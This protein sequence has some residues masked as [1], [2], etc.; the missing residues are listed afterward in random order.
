MLILKY[1]IIGIEDEIY[2]QI[3]YFPKINVFYYSNSVLN[4]YN[5]ARLFIYLS[6]YMQRSL[7]IVFA[8]TLTI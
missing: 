5:T 4:N 3:T 8:T 2:L 1:K 6:P 7:G